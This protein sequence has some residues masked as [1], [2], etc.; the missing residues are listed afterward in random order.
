[1]GGAPMSKC[2]DTGRHQSLT[3]SENGTDL[4]CNDCGAYLAAA[5]VTFRLRGAKMGLLEARR[6]ALKIKSD[7]GDGTVIRDH[8]IPTDIT[9]L[10][11]YVLA[12][13]KAAGNSKEEPKDE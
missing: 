11:D 10:C 13:K 1:M 9:E 12:P 8:T 6:L 4:V 5:D 7:L 3:L 2:A